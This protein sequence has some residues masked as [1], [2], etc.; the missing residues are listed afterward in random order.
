MLSKASNI[1]IFTKLLNHNVQFF[2]NFLIKVIFLFS[3]KFH[4]LDKLKYLM[5]HLIFILTI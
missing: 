4:F 3:N 2:L 1:Y 5:I